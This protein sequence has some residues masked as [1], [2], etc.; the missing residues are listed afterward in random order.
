MMRKAYKSNQEN[1]IIAQVSML[2]IIG[3]VVLSAFKLYAGIVGR[4]G[5]MVSD[6][7]HSM[8][9][10]AASAIAWF[11]VRISR[12]DADESHPYGHERIECIA[13]LLL[14][15]L[16]FAVGI[17]IG[18]EGISK[19]V[20]GA[21]DTLE[22]PGGIA[23]AA[24]IVSILSKEAMYWYTR[25]YAILL[26]STA[27]MADAWHHRS[28]ALSSVGSLIGIGGAM[29]GFPVLDPIASLVI[30][31]CILKVAVDTVLDALKKML[32]T[33]CNA[34]Y[35]KELSD[36]VTSQQGVI[37]LDLLRTRMFG[38]KVYVDLEIAV[39][40]N[41]SFREAHAI[42]ER[43]HSSVEEKFSN[44]KH[45]MIHVNPASKE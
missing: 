3:N 16:L 30:C 38:S 42:A 18:K 29:L 32:D 12:V 17:G 2:A 10:I 27:F 36:Y 8:S 31:L 40:E 15:S 33:S 26:D 7:I 34:E 25:H 35:E 19:I 14:G 13:S 28:D 23:L 39:D 41:K 21:Y 44:V 37:R 45:I 24:A 20:A 6:S 11:G 9:D 5:A 1:H 22:I 4:S 43:V